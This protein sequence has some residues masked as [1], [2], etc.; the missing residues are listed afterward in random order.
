[1]G[2]VGGDL[3]WQWQCAAARARRAFSS[4]EISCLIS[5]LCLLLS[6][7]GVL[8]LHAQFLAM[9]TALTPNVKIPTMTTDSEGDHGSGP[10]S[11]SSPGVV[12][13]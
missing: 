13:R 10:G 4:G 2:G 8:L 7:R 6:S 12:M 1:M 9:V 3:D 11:G 5:R